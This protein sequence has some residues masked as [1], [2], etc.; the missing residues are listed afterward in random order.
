[1]IE[2]EDIEGN[3]PLTIT[4]CVFMVCVTLGLIFGP[5]KVAQIVCPEPG[6]CC[7]NIDLKEET[8]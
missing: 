2:P 4:I 7:G 8:V 5:K 6:T 3:W 1:M